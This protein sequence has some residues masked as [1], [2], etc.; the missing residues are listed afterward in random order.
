MTLGRRLWYAPEDLDRASHFR[1]APEWLAQALSRPQSRV[2]PVWRGQ[3]FIAA[4]DEPMAGALTPEEAQAYIESGAA[5]TFLGLLGDVAYFAL[6]L[7]HVEAPHDDP[8]LAARGSFTD[9]RRV[10]PLLDPESGALLAYARGIFYWHQR[11][12]FCGVCGSPTE[13]AEAG[14]LR[15]CTNPDCAADHHPRTD[16]AVIMLVT[17]GDRCLLGRQAAW[18]RGRYSTLAGFVEPGES[19]EV[20]VAREVFEESGVRVKDVRY[21]GS[22]PWPFPASIMLGFYADAASTDVRVDERE[23]EDARW[24]TRDEVLQGRNKGLLMPRGD[25][26]ASRLIM[27]W[28]GIEPDS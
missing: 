19:L 18:P 26:I 25:S 5:T 1:R 23:L 20:A 8:R 13:S 12:Q 14:H 10:G 17:D 11:H 28:V 3:N 22:Q 24:F 7:S 21:H 27:D 9:L 2:L 6:D 4:A 15:R 16:P